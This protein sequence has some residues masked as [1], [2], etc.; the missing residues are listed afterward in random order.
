[1]V[2]YHEFGSVQFSR[3]VVSDKEVNRKKKMQP[4]GMF[5]GIAHKSYGINIAM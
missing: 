4:R 5:K 1:M 3:S 2:K